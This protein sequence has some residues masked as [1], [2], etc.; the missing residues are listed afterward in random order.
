MYLAGPANESLVSH[1]EDDKGV[2]L[3]QSFSAKEWFK[4]DKAAAIEDSCPPCDCAVSI[5]FFL[6]M[7]P[8]LNVLGL[9][10]GA[11]S[12]TTMYLSRGRVACANWMIQPQLQ[13]PVAQ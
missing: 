9:F 13:D 3:Q 7:F 1:S 2:A 10:L 11:I 4:F 12:A 6:Y 8:T 5:N